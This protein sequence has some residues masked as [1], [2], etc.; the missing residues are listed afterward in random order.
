MNDDDCPRC[1]GLGETVCGV[2]PAC[3]GSGVILP[4]GITEELTENL[5]EEDYT[6]FSMRQGEMGK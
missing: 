5:T 6:D 3:E 1:E 2:C 4:A